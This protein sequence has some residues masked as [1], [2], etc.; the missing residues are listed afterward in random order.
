MSYYKLI[1]GE[2]FVG[3][4]SPLDFREYQRK[5]N[6]L[7]SCEEERA[8]YIQ[9]SD[10]FYRAD[11]MVPTTT[12]AIPYQS[13]DVIRIGEEEYNILREAIESGN[14]IIIDD[15]DD[16]EHVEES[17]LQGDI[18]DVTVEY[19]KRMKI[20]EMSATC[21]RVISNGFDS[22]LSDGLS[23]HFALT[24]QDQL[25]LITLSTM[26]ANGETAI[27]YHADDEL[28]KFFSAEDIET[29]I[30]A[31]TA[32]KTYHVSYFNSLKTYIESMNDI[33]EIENIEYGAQ[34]PFEYQSDVLRFL[35][36]QIEN[37]Q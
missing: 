35:L 19:V 22:V 18:T 21:N 14:D 36:S 5:H 27:P 9:I 16:I 23:H 13:V 3:I 37:G 34:I 26:L 11:W 20:S 17:D 29:I 32:F 30:S 31:A 1:N 8:Q 6:I 10:D 33:D 2:I 28:C 4:A 15:E 24:T 25:N 7:L 12:D